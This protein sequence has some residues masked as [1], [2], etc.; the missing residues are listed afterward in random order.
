[1]VDFIYHSGTINS[2]Q[3]QSSIVSES[4]LLAPSY[5]SGVNRRHNRMSEAL[6]EFLHK[7]NRAI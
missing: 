2:K 1:M 7:F 5:E 6:F 4:W 3:K